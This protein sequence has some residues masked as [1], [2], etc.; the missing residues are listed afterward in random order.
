MSLLDELVA[1][2]PPAE[3]PPDS[4]YVRTSLAE[5]TPFVATALR[6]HG[7]RGLAIVVARHRSGRLMLAP[8]VREGAGWRR[9]RPRDGAS[10]ALVEALASGLSLDNGFELRHL[11][12]VGHL[13]GERA[14]GVDQTNESVVVGGSV[15]VKWLAEPNLRPASVPDLQAHLAALDYKG[16]PAPVGSLV[17]TDSVG[18]ARPPR[19][20][21]HLAAGRPRRLGLVRQRRARAPRA[22][23]ALPR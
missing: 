21:D 3:D 5:A 18:R 13:R 23:R 6:P 22:R 16:V 1:A 14:I 19:L 20:P 10:A 7:E 11:G 2:W 17:W 15:V 4:G 8:L 9:A 12:A